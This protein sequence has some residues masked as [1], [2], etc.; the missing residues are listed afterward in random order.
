MAAHLIHHYGTPVEA[1][2]PALARLISHAFA[3]PLE[4]S[5]EWIVSQG[6]GDVRVLR[7]DPS[8]APHACLRRID[9]GQYFGG[10]AVP[11]AG[12]AGV[13]VAP[14]DR[15]RGLA[16]ELMQR[17]MI[18]AA[19]DGFALSTLYA[20]TQALYRAVGFE[21]AGYSCSM[22]L[23]VHRIDIDIRHTNVHAL[24][25]ADRPAIEACYEGFA[26]KF[27][28][29]LARG[30]YT[31]GRVREWRKEQHIPFGVRDDAGTLTGYVYLI[32]R[33]RETDGRH[34]IHLSDAAFT[35]PDAGRRLL[36]FLAQFGTM[37][38]DV[39]FTGGPMHPWLNMLGE[40]KF[41]LHLK[42]Y[43]LMRVLD[44]ARAIEARGWN[45]LLRAELH[46]RITDE[47]IPANAG[48]WIIALEGG[49]AATSR[50]G[51]GELRMDIRGFAPLYS[52]FMSAREL[53]LAGLIDGPDPALDAA[54]AVFAG[55]IP[56][57][58]DFF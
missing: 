41:E 22:T 20:S 29:R 34:D 7:P 5:R 23:P 47:L 25:D 55:S 56:W 58:T 48:N 38:H 54:D 35:T 19:A 28:G 57:M 26:R 51:R 39:Q 21:Q 2:V 16:R 8:A 50:G 4:G 53:A 10:R 15:G 45:P 1:D 46:L 36:A 14:E 3:G 52:G 17:C 42:E 6:L 24:T 44:I 18:E 43:W 37:A 12:I 11:M 27:P 49:R 13:A 40:K 30:A 31:W 33:R 9:M 32:Q